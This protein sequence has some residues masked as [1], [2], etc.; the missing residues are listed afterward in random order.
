MQLKWDK[1]LGPICSLKFKNKRIILCFCHRKSNRSFNLLDFHSILCFRC[2]GLLIGLLPAFFIKFYKFS[3]PLS[4]SLLFTILL[5]LD[6]FSQLF[7][8]ESNNYLR[9]ISG[10]LFTVGFASLTVILL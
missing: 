4:I 7:G 2:L 5:V 1:K 3:L 10:F 9:F 6:G 8:R